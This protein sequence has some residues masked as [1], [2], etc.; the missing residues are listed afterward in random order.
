MPVRFSEE[1]VGI[2]EIDYF[3]S[4]GSGVSTED[5][6]NYLMTPRLL[7]TLINTARSE[8]QD[9]GLVNQVSGEPENRQRQHMRVSN[10]K[11]MALGSFVTLWP[12]VLKA[13][14][15]KVSAYML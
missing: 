14:F 9:Q 4:P 3:P 12:E 10:E 8:P 13:T 15:I 11:L 1:N 5:S 7:L 2:S 6:P